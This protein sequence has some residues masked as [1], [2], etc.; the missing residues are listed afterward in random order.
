MFAKDE[1]ASTGFSNNAFRPIWHQKLV[2]EVAP[3]NA[4]IS[5]DGKFVITT[6]DY[7]HLGYGE[8]VVVIYGSEGKLVRR[9]RLTAFLSEAEIQNAPRSVSSIY[10]AGDHQV[11]TQNEC[12]VLQV[13]QSGGTSETTP[14]VFKTVRIRL[15][16]GD[17]VVEQ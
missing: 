12:L 15:A 9:F 14:P 4:F 3:M 10:W 16:T 5:N 7:A 2:N 8:N 1:E 6:D 11:D 13:W 17:I